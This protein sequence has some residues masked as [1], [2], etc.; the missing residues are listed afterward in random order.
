VRENG[1]ELMYR[2][3]FGLLIRLGPDSHEKEDESE[4]SNFRKKGGREVSRRRSD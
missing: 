4:A 2:L 1:R 3:S